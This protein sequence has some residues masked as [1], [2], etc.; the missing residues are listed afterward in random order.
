MQIGSGSYEFLPGISYSS[1]YNQFYY[2]G[3]INNIFRLNNNK[4]NYKLG[5]HYNITSWIGKKIN[6]NFSLSARLNYNKNE[7]IE[8]IPEIITDI[9]KKKP[10]KSSEKE[11]VEVT[12][13][14]LPESSKQ[15]R[16]EYLRE[17]VLN[18]PVCNAHLKDGKKVVFGVL[19]SV[20]LDE[21][22]L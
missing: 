13:F 20:F 22:T 15:E 4:H 8:N 14:M 1:N 7:S 2:G 3:Q 9:I 19:Y 10:S 17:K 12:A 18:C 6:R 11:K 16:W 5:D 21:W